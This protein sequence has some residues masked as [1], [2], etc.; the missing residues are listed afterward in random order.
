MSPGPELQPSAATSADLSLFEMLTPV[1]R[2]WKL[3]VGTAL[4]CGAVAAVVLLLQRPVYTAETDFT[5]E[6]PGSSGL[7]SSLVGLAG[8]AGQLGLGATTGTSVSPDFFAQLIH[9]REVLR[10]YPDD[11]VQ[12]P[13]GS[14]QETSA[15]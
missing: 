9:S 11:R 5:P 6:T 4:A 12:R 13:G 8:L 10:V 14:G 15:A 7:A 2:R 3:V 1:V